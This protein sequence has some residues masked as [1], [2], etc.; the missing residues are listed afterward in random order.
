MGSKRYLLNSLASARVTLDE[1]AALLPL[2]VLWS[3][4]EH[5]RGDQPRLVSHLSRDHRNRSSADGSR[6]AAVGPEAERRLVGVAVHHLDVLRR[7]ADL[8]SNN[9]GEGR[10]VRLAL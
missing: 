1:P 7:N 8:L 9:L 2:E 5:R 6:P 4:L 10:L 3:G